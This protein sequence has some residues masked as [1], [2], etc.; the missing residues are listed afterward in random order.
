MVSKNMDAKVLVVDDDK[1][2]LEIITR[3]LSREGFRSK[4]ATDGQVAWEMLND[5]PEEFDVV[6]L[7][8]IM[9]KLDG[10]EVLSR[11]QRHTVLRDV[12]VILQTGDIGIKEAQEGI[13]A[14]AYYYI[15]KPFDSDM[16]IAVVNAAIRNYKRQGVVSKPANTF[17]E[18]TDLMINGLFSI[19]DTNDALSLSSAISSLAADAHETS[20]ALLELLINAIEHGNLEIG[21]SLKKELSMADRV[22]EEV[23]KRLSSEEYKN[24]R[25][26]VQVNNMINDV[27]VVISDEGKGFNWNE[28]MEFDPIRFLEPNGRTIAIINNLLKVEIQYFEPGN[29]VSCKFKKK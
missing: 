16:M 5:N 9:P 22:D 18:L 4:T 17:N 13:A 29:K 15:T 19:R 1:I 8:K 11:M 25:V 12:P 27:E 10:M 7:D 20:I 14:G 21:Y 23:E 3:S 28:F 26:L 6:L 2:N 24:R